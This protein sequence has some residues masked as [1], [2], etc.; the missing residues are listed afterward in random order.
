MRRHTRAKETYEDMG[1]DE[2]TT[3]QLAPPGSDFVIFAFNG[4]NYNDDDDDDDDDDYD[5]DDDDDDDNSD[6]SRKN[7]R[8]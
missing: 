2:E 1:R 3:W 6:D 4:W 7:I 8:S 5:D